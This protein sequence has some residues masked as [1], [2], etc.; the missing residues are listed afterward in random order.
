[1][2]H[3]QRNSM[4]ATMVAAVFFSACVCWIFVIGPQVGLYTDTLVALGMAPVSALLGACFAWLAARWARHG[5]VQL[6][7][8][9]Y[10]GWLCLGL[11][12]LAICLHGFYELFIW[13]AHGI[14][15]SLF[16]YGLWGLFYPCVCLGLLSLF[17]TARLRVSMI[18]DVLIT[19]CCLAGICWY[20]V[21]IPTSLSL[22]P[23]SAV[24]SWLV[25][26]RFALAYVFGD[27]FLL[28]TLIL[29]F[30]QGLI[31]RMRLALSLIAMALLL[32]IIS[33]IVWAWLVIA[34][35]HFDP[36]KALWIELFWIASTL[37]IGLSPLYQYRKRAQQTF[38]AAS[39]APT[40]LPRH[41]YEGLLL[42]REKRPTWMLVQ[43]L[44]LPLALL[45]GG[46]CVLEAA[47]VEEA[48]N[49]SVNTLFMLSSLV[50]ILIVIR[51]FF[52]TRE[53]NALL[54]E[55]DQRFEE[56]EQVRYLVTQ[57]TD[58]LDLDALRE[59]I[60]D[61]VVS[62]FG[63]TSVMLLLIDEYAQPLTSDAHISI[64]TA[65]RLVP[66]VH[67]RI[68]GETLL[69][70]IVE[71]RKECEVFWESSREDLPTEIR[72]WQEKQRVPSMQFFPIVYQGKI[73]G[74][75][76]VARHTL[77]HTTQSDLLTAAIVRNYADQIATIIEHVYLY[78][79]AQ[80]REAFARAMANIST[81]LNLAVVEPLEISQLICSEGA[82]ALH[83]DYVIFYGRR[84]EGNLEP[85]SAS[86][87]YQTGT[88]LLSDW[89]ILRLSEYEE[90]A[91]QPFLLEASAY[92]PSQFTTESGSHVT[93]GREHHPNSRQFALRAK[94]MRHRVY[95][96][97]LAPLVRDGRLN[98]L[99]IFARSVPTD[100]TT[101]LSFDE[102]DLPHAQDF[103]EQASVAFTNAQLY[104]R[105]QSANE[106][107][108][109]L[110]QMKDQFMITA[111]HELRTPLTAV[112]GYIELIAQ[113][114]EALPP[115]QRREFLNKAQM[116]CEELAI[117]LHNVMDASRIDTEVAIKPALI[118]RVSIKNML[119]KVMVMIE[120]QVTQDQREV[121]FNVPAQLHV[122][123]DPLRLHQILMNVSTNALKYS[124]LGTPITFSA[125]RAPHEEPSVIISIADKGK[126]IA[127]QDQA[128]LFQRFYRLESDMNSPIRGSGLGLYISRR[129]IE[130]MGGKIWIESRGIPGEGSTFHL[131]LPMA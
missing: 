7:M 91:L 113:Y 6:D 56:A 20:I 44:Y 125:S 104:Q 123:A 115:E 54:V 126:G 119:E 2:Q 94:L 3:V 109:E 127:V 117:L 77:V 88:T 13:N 72:F 58:I 96:A 5:P 75:L 53:N 49:T 112:Q 99:L 74:S 111:S 15:L 98:G 131:L 33:D 21:T 28:L 30:Q 1:M 83:A 18:V 97:I 39:I 86:I 60:L 27:F 93:I 19:T 57:L 87:G 34:H 25:H 66:P 68:T 50:G 114:D 11:G 10:Y 51:H 82:T 26:L 105:I 42:G 89:P 124:P 110:D 65:S 92:R 63:F 23:A 45:L 38:T 102:S 41:L 36:L 32:N 16:R 69:Y 78:Q 95:T 76:G 106:Q 90:A 70:R 62:Q 118:N 73:L 103:V 107:L 31:A 101:D 9:S 40:T 116:G 8:P 59:R 85:I 80:E 29:L 12:L 81:R 17:A 122:Q 43:N 121:H 46:L 128:R 84:T 130:A 64:S 79:E 37:L 47:H 14:G 100:S 22:L 24:G 4:L 129:L 48:N 35:L 67:G 55:R 52:A 108:K 120:P 71:E 61:V